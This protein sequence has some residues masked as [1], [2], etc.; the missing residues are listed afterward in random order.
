MIDIENRSKS[1]QRYYNKKNEINEKQK[2]YFRDVYYTKNRDKLKDYQ[3]IYRQLNGTYPK[4]KLNY[5][6]VANPKYKISEPIK[7][8]K[9]II[10][11]F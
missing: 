9:N 4:T 11:S 2:Q 1:L 8:E 3:R 7:I 6:I 5:L 10:V